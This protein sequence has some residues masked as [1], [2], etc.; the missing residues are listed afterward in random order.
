MVHV[1]VVEDDVKLNQIVCSSLDAAGYAAHGCLNAAGAFDLLAAGGIDVIVSDIMLPGTD[2]FE[3]C[4]EVRRRSDVP[5]MF[6]TARTG[7]ED[8]LR[9]KVLFVDLKHCDM[10]IMELSLGEKQ[11]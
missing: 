8:I 9:K 7:Q 10:Q 1:L 4:K 11:E 5:I 6:I 2:G 3:I